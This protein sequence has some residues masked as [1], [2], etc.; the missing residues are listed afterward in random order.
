[1]ILY[2]IDEHRQ[3]DIRGGVDSVPPHAHGSDARGSRSGST[4]RRFIME[5]RARKGSLT[6]LRSSV[7]RL[8]SR[9]TDDD[10]DAFLALVAQ[11]EGETSADARLLIECMTA[12]LRVLR[13]AMARSEVDGLIAI[14]CAT[15]QPQ[16]ASWLEDGALSPADRDLVCKAASEPSPFADR[17]VALS[18]ATEEEAEEW[19]RE[20]PDEDAEAP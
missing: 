5:L 17:L 16:P 3:D 20:P 7:P 18:E 19:L 14:A 8:A 4:W 11:A 6:L 13:A 12:R 15:N 9:I 2:E 1:M 10:R